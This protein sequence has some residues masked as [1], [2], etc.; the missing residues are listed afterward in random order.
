MSA[1]AALALGLAVVLAWPRGRLGPASREGGSERGAVIDE[2]TQLELDP[3]VACELLAVVIAGGASLPRALTA[4]GEA[5]GHESAAVAGRLLLLGADWEEATEHLSP[6]W[7]HVVAP[8]R[9][10][11]EN[12]VDPT[13]ALRAAAAAWRSRR[14]AR[15]REEAARLA[16]RLVLP[17]GACLLP[18]FVLV[19]VVPVVLAAGGSLLGW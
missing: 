15:A 5:S 4:L 12:G 9:G 16:V 17:L 3:T 13:P 2:S 14:A 18:A 8:L 10:G 6:R 11:W 19:G 7:R 1:L